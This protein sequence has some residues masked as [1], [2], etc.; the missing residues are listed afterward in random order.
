MTATSKRT[1]AQAY[2]GGDLRDFFRLRPHDIE[3]ALREPRDV[4]RDALVAALRAYHTDLGTLDESIR[5]QLDR[6]SHPTSR[7]V[8]TGQQAGLLTGPAYSVHK[9]ADAALLAAK[10]ST[11]DMPVVPVFWVASQDHDAAEVSSATLLDMNETLH[12]VTLDLP[13]GLPVGRIAWRGAWTERLRGLLDS[14]QGPPEHRDAVGRLLDRALRGGSYAD[15]FARLMQALLGPMGVVVLDPMHPALARLFAPIMARELHSPLESTRRI[16]VA[17]DA[18]EA[19]GFEAQLRRP[20]GSTNVFLE[21]DD[22]QRRLLRFDGRTFHA[23]GTY[24]LDE[25]LDILERDP[26]RVTPAAGLRPVV[27]DAVLPTA[28]FVVGP[29]EIAYGAQLGGVYELHGLHQPLLWPRLSVTWLEP[30]VSRTLKR[31]GVT[32]GAFQADADG[33]LG[34]ALARAR[35]SAALT[36]ERLDVLRAEFDA[37]ARDIEGLDV[38]LTGAVTRA[39]VRTLARLEHLQ[40]QARR[41]LVREEDTRTQ[42]VQRLRKHLLPRGVPQEREMSFLSFVLKHGDVPLR[43][44]RELPPGWA[45][46]IE[47]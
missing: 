31:F 35:G 41:A 37:L 5:L 47:L 1:I 18:L 6:L 32:A 19:H 4:N 40:F 15:V 8:V 27:Q 7:V 9:G 34:H 12:H 11:T 29:G 30:P 45:G 14:F 28:A 36:A 23:D 24:R 46:E 25:L 33:T 21:G 10:L 44:L 17:A 3:A 2:Q 38:T 13:Q 26:S 39:K 42:Q 22:G 43:R 16:Q 20:P